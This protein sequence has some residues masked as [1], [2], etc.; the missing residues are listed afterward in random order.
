[1]QLYHVQAVHSLGDWGCLLVGQ[2]GCDNK[3]W[4]AFPMA[5]IL[6]THLRHFMHEIQHV[7]GEWFCEGYPRERTGWM[8]KYLQFLAPSLNTTS[9]LLQSLARH[10]VDGGLKF[11]Q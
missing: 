3:P 5:R 11:S 1:M 2:D 4:E 9:W 10:E 6:T 7:E 8:S